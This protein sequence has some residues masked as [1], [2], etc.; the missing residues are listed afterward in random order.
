LPLQLG[1]E[2]QGL[3]PVHEEKLTGPVDRE[4]AW[5]TSSS[6]NIR[7]AIMESTGTGYLD[8]GVRGYQDLQSRV[9][10]P[11]VSGRDQKTRLIYLCK[12]EG[13]PPVATEPACQLIP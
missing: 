4:R 7:Q 1:G 6:S 12:M 11:T 8:L 10:L 13:A 9:S 3:H 2:A 5:W